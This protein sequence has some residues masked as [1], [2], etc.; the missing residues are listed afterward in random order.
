[1]GKYK[2]ESYNSRSRLKDKQLSIE[3]ENLRLKKVELDI[4]K[5][6]TIKEYVEKKKD[7]KSITNIV[8]GIFKK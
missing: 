8:L 5:E 4:L 3:I 7:K 6:S 2:I 1:M